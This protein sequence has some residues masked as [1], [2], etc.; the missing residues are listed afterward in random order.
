[1][2]EKEVF[3]LSRLDDLHGFYKQ[4][5]GWQKPDKIPNVQYNEKS[6]RFS[7]WTMLIK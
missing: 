7:V 6:I 2:R 5:P 4:D 1:M 3:A